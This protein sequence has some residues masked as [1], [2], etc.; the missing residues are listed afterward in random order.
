M[1]DNRYF[2]Y[3]CPAKMQDGTFIT[4]Y[5]RPRIFDQYIRTINNINSAQE[6]KD[7]L[8]KNTDVIINRERDYHDT[9]NVCKINGCAELSANTIMLNIR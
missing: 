4:N 2:S 1:S 8:Q 9:N 6:Y 7:F 3:N 5:T